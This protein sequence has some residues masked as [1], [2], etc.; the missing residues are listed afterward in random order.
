VPLTRILIGI[1]ALVR[2][3]E[4]GRVLWRVLD[5]EVLR[6]PIISWL[7]RPPQLAVPLL[8]LVW[9]ALA[10]A[11]TL[12]HRTRV[13][14]TAL[15]I[16]MGYTL[17]LD[18]QTYSNHLYLL[19]LIVGVLALA[20]NAPQLLR[21]QLSMVY[22]F[23]ALW[24]C[25]AYY[26]SGAV[27][28]AHLIPPLQ[29]WR[30]FEYMAPLAIASVFLEVFLAI[31]FWSP[32]WRPVA[33]VVGLSLHIGCVLILAPGYQVQIAVFALEMI[34]LYTAFGPPPFRVFRPNFAAHLRD[35]AFLRRVF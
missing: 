26:L 9:L 1:A 29:Q 4:A 21:W 16:L 10:A 18:Q 14:G 13:T 31:A 35:H 22:G 30:Q 5:P 33:W 24:K 7:P 20:P 23:S 8:V 32:R 34:A 15:A 28:A 6:L 19:L 3:L 2:G 25:N 27:I 12:G 11:F 17:L